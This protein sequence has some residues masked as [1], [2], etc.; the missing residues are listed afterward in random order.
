MTCKQFS[1]CTTIS[2]ISKQS[3]SFQTP[4][5]SNKISSFI[6]E[7]QLNGI[8]FEETE[9]NDEADQQW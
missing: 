3:P 4:V 2:I 6:P 7:N 9:Q 1:T 8:N 5:S